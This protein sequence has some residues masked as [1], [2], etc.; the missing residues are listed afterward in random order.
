MYKRS[1]KYYV[2]LVNKSINTDK[3]IHIFKKELYN[4]DKHIRVTL[5]K[6]KRLLADK[7]FEYL[8]HK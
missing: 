4:L 7:E 8:K 3:N 6:Q 5:L 1:V 2:D